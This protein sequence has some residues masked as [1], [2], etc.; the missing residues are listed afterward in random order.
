M[1][2]PRETHDNNGD[3]QMTGNGEEIGPRGRAIVC[4]FFYVVFFT[5]FLLFFIATNSLVLTS[6]PWHRERCSTMTTMG[7]NEVASGR[8]Q[9]EVDLICHSLDKV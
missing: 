8:G 6:M 3:W 4:F 9:V 1:L 2:A 7:D 5:F